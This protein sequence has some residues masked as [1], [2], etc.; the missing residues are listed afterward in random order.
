M[1]QDHSEIAEPLHLK[2][3]PEINPLRNL[4]PTAIILGL[5]GGGGGEGHSQQI[6]NISNFD[7]NETR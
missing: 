1:R 2:T 5:G 3:S 6:F 4:T 7:S